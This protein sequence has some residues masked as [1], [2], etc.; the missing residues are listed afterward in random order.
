MRQLF[1]R[2]RHLLHS[3]LRTQLLQASRL[4]LPRRHRPRILHAIRQKSERRDAAVHLHRV[5]RIHAK[6][7]ENIHGFA[8]QA[9][10]FSHQQP[11]PRRPADHGAKYR[12]RAAAR[13]RPVGTGHED[14]KP[15]D[16]HAKV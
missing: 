13:H 14:A 6:G 2:A 11:T 12:R 4:L 5:R 10:P 7:E 8:R 15:L 3:P 16:A 1:N 9:E